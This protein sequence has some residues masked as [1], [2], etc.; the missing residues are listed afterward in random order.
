MSTDWKR[1]IIPRHQEEITWA[2]V[3]HDSFHHGTDGHHKLMLIAQMS[4]LLTEQSVFLDDIRIR[5]L[6][7]AEH[8]P[9]PSDAVRMLVRDIAE[10]IRVFTQ[11]APVTQEEAHADPN[12]R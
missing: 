1:R 11:Y 8:P 2:E 6:A 7:L 4:R 9:V 12:Q 10:R 5:L 3:Y